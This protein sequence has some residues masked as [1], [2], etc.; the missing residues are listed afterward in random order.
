MRLM[1]LFKE[2]LPQADT[3]AAQGLNT[4][5]AWHLQNSDPHHR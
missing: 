4:S 1:A 5:N 2:C 3:L